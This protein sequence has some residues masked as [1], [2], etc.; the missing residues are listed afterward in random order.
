MNLHPTYP[1]FP[2]MAFL[3]FV[4]IL[5]PLAWI[6]RDN[7]GII[8]L[9]LWTATACLNQFV[10]SVI[11][12]GNTR[13]FIPVF[14]DISSRL[15][16][17]H[18]TALP[19]SGLCMIRRLY[20]ICSMKAFHL[21]PPQKRKALVQDLCICLGVPFL[22][23]ALDSGHRYDIFEDL[24]CYPEANNTWLAY[25]LFYSWPVVLS[26]IVGV[27][28]ILTLRIIVKNG[29]QIGEVM[30][31]KTQRP[32]YYRIIIL[33]LCQLILLGPFQLTIMIFGL[34]FVPIYP[35]K[36]WDDTHFNYSRVDEIPAALWRSDPVS[37]AMHEALRWSV[38]V[39][40]IIYYSLFGFSGEA[41][42]AYWKA[43]WKVAGLAGLKPGSS[44][45]QV[46]KP[47]KYVL[48]GAL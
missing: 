11:W 18:F 10:N 43:F 38:V 4:A 12:H 15:M 27:Y 8:F 28:S 37:E 31:F 2:I 45:P 17:A 39:W 19:A 40:A 1:A 44:S 41:R 22:T 9:F 34:T 3:S 32:L 16:V 42:N 36:S 5:L 20:H 6:R 24:G 48:H 13:N 26:L 46:E 21:T 33:S 29:K 14:C 23:M 35:Y 7:F 25:V 47:F 30:Q